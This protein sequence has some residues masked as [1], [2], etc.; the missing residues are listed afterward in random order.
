M[1]RDEWAE[2]HYPQYYWNGYV[3]DEISTMGTLE[4]VGEY[5]DD[6]WRPGK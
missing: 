3:R 1:S 5:R 6:F 4:V 2:Q